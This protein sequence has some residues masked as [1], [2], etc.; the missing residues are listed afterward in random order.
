[1]ETINPSETLTTIVAQ[2]QAIVGD[3]SR[4]ETRH[5]NCVDVTPSKSWEDFSK[6][7]SHIAYLKDDRWKDLSIPD[8]IYIDFFRWWI[9]SEEDHAFLA[10]M[11]KLSPRVIDTQT[12]KRSHESE[13]LAE[14]LRSILGNRVEVK[15][16]ENDE[17]DIQPSK[18]WENVSALSSHLSHLKDD[19]WKE[20][21]TDKRIT[22]F[23]WWIESEEDRAFLAEIQRLCPNVDTWQTRNDREDR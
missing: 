15:I 12:M 8:D 13:V 10:E 5:G 18:P 17:I 21:S 4:V 3:R 23:R 19:R 2:I 1:M 20:I 7:T 22:F 14:H 9:S 11:K 16:S 6:H